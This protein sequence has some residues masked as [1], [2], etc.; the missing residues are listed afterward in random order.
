MQKIYVDTAAWIALINTRDALHT[1]AWQVFDN[2]QKRVV[3][4][5]RV[6][7]V[8][9]D[10]VS[11]LYGYTTQKRKTQLVTTEFILLEVADALSSPPLRAK[12]VTFINRLRQHSLLEI[13]P[14]S[15]QLL[16]DGWVLYCQRPDKE[17][18]LTDCIS[19]SVM[20]QQQIMDAFTSD[21][22]FEQAGF[23]ILLK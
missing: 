14:A 22:H 12:A 20:T 18:S 3:S 4:L 8:I 17:W 2:L 5:Y 13:L 16:A 19:F 11:T 7:K 9:G 21:H 1:L 6:D 10:E 15:A 23:R